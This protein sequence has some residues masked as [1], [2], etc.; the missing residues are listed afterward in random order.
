[1]EGRCVLHH[2]HKLQ[3]LCVFKAWGG[4]GRWP[5]GQ[6]VNK[7]ASKQERTVCSMPTKNAGP[8]GGGRG[9]KGGQNL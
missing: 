5:A 6:T 9:K 1:M 3:V 8:G 4:G 7:K 2:A